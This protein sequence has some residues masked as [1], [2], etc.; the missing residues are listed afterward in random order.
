MNDVAR[1]YRGVYRNNQWDISQAE[2]AALDALILMG[3]EQLA[4]DALGVSVKTV[5][6][7]VSRAKVRM[8]MKTRLLALIA[9]DRRTRSLPDGKE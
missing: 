6:A 2:A 7:Q 1:P 4:A 8:G 3:S 9:W 5:S